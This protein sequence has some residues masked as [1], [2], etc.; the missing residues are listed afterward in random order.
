MVAEG[1]APS[2]RALYEHRHAEFERQLGV[3]W[4]ARDAGHDP[5]EVLHCF[6]RAWL[7]MDILARTSR[8]RAR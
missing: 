7:A 4:A 8:W 3:M 6:L 2:Y 1:L 5:A